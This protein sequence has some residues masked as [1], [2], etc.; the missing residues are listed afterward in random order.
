MK[1]HKLAVKN[2][3]ILFFFSYFL[4]NVLNLISTSQGELW[5]KRSAVWPL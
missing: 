3:L 4:L 5:C 2:V 1:L